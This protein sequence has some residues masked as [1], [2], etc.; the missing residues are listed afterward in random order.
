MSAVVIEVFL[1]VIHIRVDT[2]QGKSSQRHACAELCGGYLYVVFPFIQTSEE[3]ITVGV[4][5]VSSDEYV[6]AAADKLVGACV[7]QFHHDAG[8]THFNGV[9]I[10]NAVVI[11]IHKNRR[12]NAHCRCKAEV[13]GHI[14]VVVVGVVLRTAAARLCCRFGICNK[15]ELRAHH[16]AAGAAHLEAVVVGVGCVIRSAC[17]DIFAG[18]R[19]IGQRTA[20]SQLIRLNLQVVF[21]FGQTAHEE[22]AVVISY[23]TANK[24]VVSRA[25]DAVG[26]GAP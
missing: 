2:R 1:V 15:Q 6:V 4:R 8:N 24:L 10:L 20:R 12:A 18:K 3:I 23:I 16:H 14:A 25:F 17:S 26:A 9:G 13:F 19:I 11:E 21:T 5:Y 7:V 22:V